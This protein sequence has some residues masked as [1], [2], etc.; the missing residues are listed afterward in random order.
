MLVLKAVVMSCGNKTLL[1]TGASSIRKLWKTCGQNLRLRKRSWLTA[2]CSKQ[3]T[4]R[5]LALELK[6]MLVNLFVCALVQMMH[7]SCQHGPINFMSAFAG[8]RLPDISSNSTV[9]LAS[10]CSCVVVIC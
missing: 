1:I 6:M 8:L 2:A 7:G 9:L 4:E 10:S 3:M 5:L